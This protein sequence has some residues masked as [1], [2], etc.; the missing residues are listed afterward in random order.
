MLPWCWWWWCKCWGSG[1]P[2]AI[3]AP[4]AAAARLLIVCA[5]AA[6]TEFLFLSNC[7]GL[8]TDPWLPT[9]WWWWWCWW[10]VAP[11]LKCGGIGGEIGSSIGRVYCGGDCRCWEGKKYD[12]V[13]CTKGLLP[14]QLIGRAMAAHYT[15]NGNRNLFWGKNGNFKLPT[16]AATGD[17]RY[18]T[19]YGETFRDKCCKSLGTS[20]G[21]AKQNVYPVKVHNRCTLS[22]N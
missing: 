16:A 22:K 11:A 13:S 9:D 19:P 3:T 2:G 6:F 15:K 4:P 7:V 21:F 5:D 8:R 10:C 1:W 12:L 14:S 18:P 17:Q 20:F